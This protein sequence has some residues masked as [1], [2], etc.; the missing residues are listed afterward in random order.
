MFLKEL[1]IQGYKNFK[2]KF[3]IEF[4]QGLNVLVG[5]NGTGK[6]AIIDAIRLVLQEDE[7][8][9]TP[10]GDSDFHKP[11]DHPLNRSKQI[12]I[13]ANFDSLTSEESI[14][15][16][17][18][19][20]LNNKARLTLQHDSPPNKNGRYKRTIW[21]G[22]SK[23]S[24]FEPELFD[25]IKC[26][27]LPP[28]RDAEAK[29]R[30][31]RTSRLARLLKNLNSKSLA[32]ARAKDELHSLEKK[33]KNFNT[34]IASDPKES[35][36][37]ANKLIKDRLSEA[38]GGVF[39][40]DTLIQF[41]E[42]DLNRIVDNLRLLFF[43]KILAGIT[44]DKFRNLDENSLG[45]NNLLYFATV[46]AELT[47]D[48][49]EKN[50]LKVLL[51]E[52]PEAHLHPQLQIRL[53]KYLEKTAKEKN[54]QVIVTTHSTVLAS[55]VT[56]DT[57]IHLSNPK[58]SE[59]FACP[60][61]K[62]GLNPDSTAFINRWLDV[63]KSNLLF[64]KGIILVEGIAEAMLLPV[65][66]KSILE[67]YNSGKTTE[68]KLPVSL[69]DGGISVINMNG[70]YFGYFMQL[71]CDLEVN[72]SLNIPIRCAGITDNDPRP[73]KSMPT[74]LSIIQGSNHALKLIPVVN[75]SVHARLFSNELKT[76]EYD[77]SFEGDN[78][79]YM[80]NVAK[81]LISTDGSIL[82][83]LIEYE[84]YDWQTDTN[85]DQKRKAAYFLLEHIDKGVYAQTLANYLIDKN[86]DLM[87]PSYIK[88]AII[89]ACGGEV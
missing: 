5:E 89:W 27:Y 65:F 11:F 66:A 55:S 52:E 28:L 84:N 31:G 39:G 74:P 73:K 78:I 51:I 36:S 88:K 1:S 85:R 35:I 8:G 69:E 10:I 44:N 49:E 30:E 17:P 40:Q 77:L 68:S 75:Q 46:M 14:A 60:I 54:V 32:E 80:I 83:Q 37:I 56:I 6:T 2:E 34:D 33:V 82:R 15:F 16:L 38:M 29:L 50:Y 24:M 81:S 42:V 45:Y 59:Y 53:L 57:L 63:T 87:I 71:F 48:D 76:F 64:A 13:I 9:R 67:E 41:S 62:C 20:D 21:G 18:W 72:K 19:T 22:A 26:I 12:E 4:Q 61:R 25:T 3:E 43:P 86:I 79:I 58:T 7:F 47:I 23:A 70:I